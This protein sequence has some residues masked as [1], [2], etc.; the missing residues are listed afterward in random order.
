MQVLAQ[1]RGAA[2]LPWEGH[3][4]T[5]P[6]RRSLGIFHGPVLMLLRRNPRQR[7][8][9]QAFCDACNDIVHQTTTLP[10]AGPTH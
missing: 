10:T 9:M 3:G 5:E 4:L 2:L 8:S 6:T 7:S 1:L